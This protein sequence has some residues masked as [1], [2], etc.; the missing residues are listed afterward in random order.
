MQRIRTNEAP[1]YVG[2]R[3]RLTGWMHNWRDMGRFG[4]LVL[5][6]GA[7]TFQ[8]VLEDAAEIAKLKGL[9]YETVLQVEGTIVEEPRAPG[10]TELRHC[11]VTV[12]SPV[13]EPLPFE[14]NKKEL[15]PGLDVFLDNAP[16]GLRHLHKRALFRISAEI[17]AGFRE[18]LMQQGFVEIQTPKIVGSAT[19]SGANVFALDYF[20]RPAYLAQ[21]PQF[22]KQIMVG[23]FERVFEIGPVFRAEKHNTA[24]HTNEY[25][26]LDIEMGFIQDHTDVMV[27]LTGILRHIFHRLIQACPRELALLKIKVPIIGET[28]PTLRLPDAQQLIFER[29]GEDCRGEP[30]LA[31]QHEAWLCEYAEQALGSELLFITHYPTAKRPF[32]AM[33]DDQDPNLTKSFDLLFRGCEIVTGGQRIHRYEQ[34]LDNARKWGINPE[35]IAGYLQAF[36]FGMPPHGG[37][38]M[39]LERL[40]MQLAGLKNLREATLFPRDLDRVTP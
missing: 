19:E 14:I 26:S 9:Q 33:P 31:P 22:Y 37:F 23:V 17:M 32:Y 5:R 16:I 15:K 12:I 7:G 35:D 11:Q 24:R 36:K 29:Y 21:S 4:F 20:G 3:I 18:Y 8:A 27:V 40:L 38:G 10:G 30:D 39:G 13:L 6:D 28:I 1:N 2:K 34:L 25:V